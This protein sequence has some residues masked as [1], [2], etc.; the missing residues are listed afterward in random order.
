MKEVLFVILSQ[1]S[2]EKVNQYLFD[3]EP[4]SNMQEADEIINFY[5]QA[6]PKECNRW[7]LVRKMMV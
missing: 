2:N 6:E 4:L 7:I 3:Y 1:F 5:V